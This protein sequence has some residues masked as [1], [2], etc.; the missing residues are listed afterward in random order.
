[1]KLFWKLDKLIEANSWYHIQR[2]VQDSTHCFD[3]SWGKD[4]E[5]KSSIPTTK[6]EAPELYL[7]IHSSIE[8]FTNSFKLNKISI[9]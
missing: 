3:D 5:L 9:S 8:L 7:S 1:M 4:E 2:F 6:V